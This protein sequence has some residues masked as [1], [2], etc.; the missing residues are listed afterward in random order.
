LDG[1]FFPLLFRAEVLERPVQAFLLRTQRW[2]TLAQT[3]LCTN[4]YALLEFYL[5]V[6]EVLAD[7]DVEAYF[8]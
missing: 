5:E 4:A 7:T 3:P 8:N 2:L 6:T 1:I